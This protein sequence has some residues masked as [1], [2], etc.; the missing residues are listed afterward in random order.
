MRIRF[1][2]ALLLTSFTGCLSGQTGSPDCVGATSCVCDP[3]Y[4]GGTLLRVRAESYGDGKLAAVVEEAFSSIH[5]KS[6]VVAGDRVGGSVLA[7]RPCAAAPTPSAL[8]GSELFVL[9]GP[10][11]NGGYPNC[12]ALQSCAASDCAQLSEPELTDC[13]NACDQ[14]TQAACADFRRAALLD[15]VFSWAVPWTE[16][17]DFGD[18]KALP[19]ADLDVLQSPASC[20]QRF[21]ASQAPP[22]NDVNSVGCQ[23]APRGGGWPCGWGPWLLG[24]FALV[25][26]VRRRLLA[27]G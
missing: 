11:Q 25:F 27:S 2:L 26:A 6:D 17:L 14:R 15:G 3:L 1:A 4:G 19:S 7:E 13:W 24:A 8:V 21:P 18:A 20:L 10:G 5:T 12:S 9:Y 23:A 16:P 22:C